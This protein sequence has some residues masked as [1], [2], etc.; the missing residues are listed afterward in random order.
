MQKPSTPAVV[1]AA[2]LLLQANG[3]APDAKDSR[4]GAKVS[5]VTTVLVVGAMLVALAAG[6]VLAWMVQAGDALAWPIQCSDLFYG[7]R[8]TDNPDRI[9]ESSADDG[10]LAMDGDDD[11]DAAR[12]AGDTDKVKGGRGDDTINAADGDPFDAIGCGGG[13]DVAIFDPGD[14]VAGSCEETTAI[15]TTTTTTTGGPG[16]IVGGR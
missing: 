16:P 5:R 15:T 2:V 6:V 10:I 12:F 13:K 8:G 3:E 9:I 11:V 4:Q 14:Y 1:K 7:C